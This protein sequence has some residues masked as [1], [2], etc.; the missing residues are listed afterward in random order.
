MQIKC[1]IMEARYWLNNLL[2]S[3]A[4]QAIYI[5]LMH[6]KTSNLKLIPFIPLYLHLIF[7]KGIL[8]GWFS[9][10]EVERIVW[11]ILNH[12][13]C[14]FDLQTHPFICISLYLCL[15]WFFNSSLLWCVC[16]LKLI[17][18]VMKL[19]FSELWHFLCIQLLKYK[20]SDLDHIYSH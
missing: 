10:F 13:T 12:F 7:W 16:S 3:D 19:I 2:I 9:H 11:K 15:I 14:R 5:F 18:L 6:S 4:L 17:L 1:K 8:M 20:S